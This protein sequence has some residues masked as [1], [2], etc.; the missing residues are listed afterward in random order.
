[1]A[2]DPTAR[3]LVVGAGQ[4][5]ISLV[6]ALRE[7]G[8]TQPVV[9]V[10]DEPEPPYERPPLSKTYMRGEHDRASLIFHDAAWFADLGVELVTGDAVATVGRDASGG[11]ATT[12]SGRTLAFDRLALTTGAVNRVLPVEGAALDGVHSVRTLGDADRLAPRLR[13]A[14]RV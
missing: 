1:M 9:L 13:S 8:G 12:A 4:A 6:T 10:G 7:L 14:R 5:G 3:T 2:P 11:V